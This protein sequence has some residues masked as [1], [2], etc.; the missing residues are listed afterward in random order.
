MLAKMYLLDNA[1]KE[2][3]YFLYIL[4]MPSVDPQV[5]IP[6][7]GQ[8]NLQNHAPDVVCLFLCVWGQG[9]FF[10]DTWHSIGLLSDI[11]L[12]FLFGFFCKDH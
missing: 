7:I 1:L 2:T 8:S 11:G 10:I 12:S 6:D 3:A 5:W 4:R 9:A